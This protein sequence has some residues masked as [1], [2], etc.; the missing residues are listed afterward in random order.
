MHD[1]RRII[2]TIRLKQINGLF[3]KELGG[4]DMIL[5]GDWRQ[6]LPVKATQIFKQIKRRIT[7]ISNETR[8]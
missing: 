7:I 4:L 6:L 1:F 2:E 3:T 8:K 5:I